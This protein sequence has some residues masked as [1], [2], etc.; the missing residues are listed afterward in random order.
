VEEVP[1]AEE[2]VAAVAA[3]GSRGDAGEGVRSA[4]K[5]SHTSTTRKPAGCEI[6]SPSVERSCPGDGRERAPSI[7]ASLPRR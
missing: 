2:V 3:A 1:V 6:F 7:S 4:S 5:K